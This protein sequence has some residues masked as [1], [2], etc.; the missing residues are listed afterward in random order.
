MFAV[1]TRYMGMKIERDEDAALSQQ[2]PAT[3]GATDLYDA[4]IED[5]HG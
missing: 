3:A 2:A 4:L 1:F 5:N